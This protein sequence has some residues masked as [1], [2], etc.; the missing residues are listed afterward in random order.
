MAESGG[1]RQSRE[2]TRPPS[3]S[4]TPRIKNETTTATASTDSR[5]AYTDNR[6]QVVYGTTGMGLRTSQ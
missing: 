3:R 4:E 5:P 1:K 2:E 6:A